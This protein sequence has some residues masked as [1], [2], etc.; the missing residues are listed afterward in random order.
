[1]SRGLLSAHLYPLDATIAWIGFKDYC[2][3]DF[4]KIP[5]PTKRSN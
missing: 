2:E 5:R 1:M 3:K 4:G